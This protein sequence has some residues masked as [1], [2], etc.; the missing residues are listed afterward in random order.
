MKLLKV[1]RG[2]FT[3]KKHNDVVH[4]H[5]AEIVTTKIMEMIQSCYYDEKT[6]TLVVDLP[7][8]LIVTTQGSQMFVAKN[9]F[10]IDLADKI[11]LNP[12]VHPKSKLSINRK[13]SKLNDIM[14]VFEEAI[15]KQIER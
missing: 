4:V 3:T 2:L 8:N 15:T 9:G 11:H 1:M 5:N 7:T 14:D 12:T 10:K 6:N 13:N